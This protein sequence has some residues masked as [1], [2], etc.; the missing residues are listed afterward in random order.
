VNP[1]ARRLLRDVEVQDSATV[2]ADHE[3]TV[4]H[5]EPEC[6]DGEEVHRRNKVFSAGIKCFAKQNSWS[7]YSSRVDQ[8]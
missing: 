5:V 1:Q 2:V 4:E 7:N 3:E 8:G 6:W